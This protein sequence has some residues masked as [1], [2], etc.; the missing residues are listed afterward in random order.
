MAERDSQEGT[1][2]WNGAGAGVLAVVGDGDTDGTGRVNKDDGDGTGEPAEEDPDGA[3]AGAGA[4]IKPGLGARAAGAGTEVTA[5]GVGLPEAADGRADGADTTDGA[6]TVETTPDA[7]APC[8]RESRICIACRGACDSPALITSMVPS[9]TIT[10]TAAVAVQPAAGGAS[11]GT[12]ELD[13]CSSSSF[14]WPH[15]PEG[16][17]GVCVRLFC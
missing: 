16:P 7:G 8:L 10:K 15:L 17:K 12:P 9:P 2:S 1:V 11:D 14:M 4:G 3:R 5:G 6:G 13:P